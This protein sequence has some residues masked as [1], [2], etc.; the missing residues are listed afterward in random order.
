MEPSIVVSV[1]SLIL[2]ASVAY[3]GAQRGVSTRV[4]ALEAKVD[5][6]TGKVEK[7]NGAMERLAALEARIEMTEK[8]ESRIETIEKEMRA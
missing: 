3:F 5:M 2:T 6:L 8:L 7:H 1:I 4:A